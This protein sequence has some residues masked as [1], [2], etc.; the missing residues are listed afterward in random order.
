MVVGRMSD[1]DTSNNR[2]IVGEKKTRIFRINQM[3]RCAHVCHR[4]VE[5]SIKV[6]ESKGEVED[7]KV[8]FFSVHLPKGVNR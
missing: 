5:T 3:P 1:A 8:Y 4:R 2:E 7:E 6:V